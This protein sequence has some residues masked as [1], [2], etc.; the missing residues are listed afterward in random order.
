MQGTSD[1]T[2]DTIG[3][4][5]LAKR[6]ERRLDQGRAAAEIG[7]SPSTYRSYEKNTQRPSVNVF[8]LLAKF[9]GLEMEDFLQLYGATVIFALRPALER[10]LALLNGQ[11][12]T[13]PPYVPSDSD[14]E[15]SF[16]D[17]ADDAGD[18]TLSGGDLDDHVSSEGAHASG[19]ESFSYQREEVPAPSSASDAVAQAF[20]D[21][22]VAVV[23]VDE[24]DDDD[25]DDDDDENDEDDDANDDEDVDDEAFFS[26][27]MS[28]ESEAVPTSSTSLFTGVP[29]GFAQ[30]S[31][32]KKKKKKK[33]K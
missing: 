18:P 23:V 27:D 19:S 28:T 16:D 17:D 2:S 29:S 5:L 24:E 26:K 21:P 22:P 31:K 8:P 11:T 4:A 32:P 20:E 1:L 7:V 25:D 12:P 10:E 14:S 6:K 30:S 3:D 13:A 15:D 33:K 9:L